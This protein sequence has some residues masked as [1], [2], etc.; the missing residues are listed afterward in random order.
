ML[1]CFGCSCLLTNYEITDNDLLAEK[2]KFTLI[3]SVKGI[4]C[5]I[6][7]YLIPHIS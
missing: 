4:F 7:Y 3:M 2:I 1:A 6:A 5:D